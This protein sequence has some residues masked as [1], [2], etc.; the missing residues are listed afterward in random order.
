[1]FDWVTMNDSNIVHYLQGVLKDLHGEILMNESKICSAVN[2]IDEYQ[3]AIERLS[4]HYKSLLNTALA[5]EDFDKEEFE[6][7]L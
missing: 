3:R 1:M 2:R 7:G 5:Y 4:V 6:S